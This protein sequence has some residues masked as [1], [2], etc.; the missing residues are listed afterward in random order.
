MLNMA[1]ISLFWNTNVASA[2]LVE[3]LLQ[4]VNAG[5]QL[6]AK[7]IFGVSIERVRNEN[8][9]VRCHTL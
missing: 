9:R 2:G 3:T 4:L 5:N 6:R 8:L 7:L 1:A